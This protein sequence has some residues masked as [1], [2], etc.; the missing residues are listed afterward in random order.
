M[1]GGATIFAEKLARD[2]IDAGQTV[3]LLR[4]SL[5]TLQFTL[6]YRSVD[7][8]HRISVETIPELLAGLAD[9]KPS[10]VHV[11]NTVS[12]PQNRDILQLL[13]KLTLN[14]R[15]PTYYYLHDYYSV[16]PSFT[17]LNSKGAFC[18]VP[19]PETC[20][21]CLKAHN[22][23]FVISQGVE[24]ILVWRRE[25][26][27]FFSSVKVIRFFSHSSRELFARAFPT[28]EDKKCIVEPHLAP[29][30]TKR[31][32]R[33]SSTLTIAVV[34]TIH[35]AKG[36]LR[37]RALCD[38]IAE[39][40]LPARIVVVGSID[41]DLPYEFVTTTGP[42][43]ARDLPRILA[44]HGANVAFFSSVW[45]ETFS[46]VVSEL[47]AIGMPVV[48]F[49]LG[50]PAERIGEGSGKLVPLDSPPEVVF[51]A[52]Q[53]A[54]ISPATSS[55]TRSPAKIC[56]F[57][58]A[59][60][61]YLPKAMVL[62]RSIKSFHPEVDLVYGLCDNK[63]DDVDYL[64]GIFDEVIAADE[65]D[66]PDFEGWSFRHTIVELSTAIKT[67]L[68]KSLLSRGYDQVYY[69][70]PDIVV[71]SS[72]DD[73]F[74]SGRQTSVLLTPHQTAP[75]TDYQSIIDN[76]IASLKYGVYNLGFL[77]V[78]NTPI[79]RA[80]SSWWANRL[81]EWC[82][83]DIPNGLF[84]DQRWIDLAPALFGDVAIE[85]SPRFNV[86]TWNVT[87][88][89]VT[90]NA[91]DG[92]QVDGLPLG[93][94]H[95]TGFDKGDHRIMAEKNSRGNPAVMDL[96]N[97]YQAETSPAAASPL[98]AIPWAFAVYDDGTQIP[99][100]HRE[101]YRTRKD[102]QIAFP[103]PFA[104]TEHSGLRQW[105]STEGRV[106]SKNSSATVEG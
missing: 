43:A 47:Q 30:I 21:A 13:Q 46:F 86:S 88:R 16:C 2:A 31:P 93:F 19:G 101:L 5:G 77:G 27:Q 62:G 28:I 98:S 54:A 26:E 32:L 10:E 18:G 96:V 63:R 20:S 95:F 1:G 3:C 56:V 12:F 6:E 84:T 73:L 35:A 23:P 87:Q 82:V 66:I 64:A 60:T 29:E 25:W 80:F 17:L 76:E 22:D 38:Y 69:F 75:E 74:E 41:Q 72:L 61:N 57:T 45:P 97:W 34:G 39:H 24:S 99:V 92:Y 36:S 78:S 103:H 83:D 53:S 105:I 91:T 65:L 44:T 14:G 70:D 67:F 48:A 55:H 79:G 81:Y 71:F 106:K 52:L 33:P 11:N 59:A 58:S 85:R 68:L 40:N 50:A 8:T 51:S 102:L 49:D 104:S 9:L 7:S 37:V 89:N 100:G 4:Y 90:G 15:I 42:Y 94:Y